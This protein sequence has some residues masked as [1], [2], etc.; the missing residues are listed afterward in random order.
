MQITERFIKLDTPRTSLIF[1]RYDELLETVYYGQRVPDAEDFDILSSHKHKYAHS[2]ID[3]IVAANMTFSCYGMGNDR[4]FSLSVKNHDG[5]YANNFL[6]VRAERVEKP[7]I[8]GLPS[9]DG[10]AETLVLVYEDRVYG[11]ELRQYYSVFD[12]T[13]AVAVSARLINRSEHAVVLRSLASCQL[14][15]DGSGYEIFSYC[16]TWARERYRSRTVLHTGVFEQGTCRGSS[17]HAVNPFLLLRR[18]ARMGGYL[19]FN[20]VYSGNHREC[21]ESTAMHTTRILIGMG[22]SCL[23]IPLG[24]G[25]RFHTPEAVMLFGKHRRDVAQQMH[26]FVNG[27]IVPRRYRG[28]RPVAVN[29]WEACGFDFD[30]E[31]VLAF[32][33]RAASVGAELLVVDDGWFGRRS[34][35]T[36]SLGDW[37]DNEQKTGGLRSLAAEVRARGLKFGIWI[38]PEMVSPDSD[39][40]RAHP[41]YVLRNPARSPILMRDQLV[42]DLVRPEVSDYLFGCIERLMDLCSPE[43][44]KWDFNR[45]ITDAYHAPTLA[46]DA[47]SLQYCKAL[48]ALLDRVLT[49]WPHL[50][51]ESCAAGGGRY[52]LGMLRYTP[53]VWTSDMTDPVERAHIQEGTLIAYPQSTMSAHVASEVCVKTGRRTRLCDR[54]A[55]ALEGVFGLEYDITQCRQEEL[56]ELRA[57]I[58]FYKNYRDVLLYG[59]YYPVES[60][61]EGETAVRVVVSADKSRAV[62][63]IFKLKQVF[64]REQNRYRLEGLN[65]EATYRVRIYGQ[66]REFRASGRLLNSYG[67]ELDAYFLKDRSGVY[68]NEIN[69][70][71]LAIERC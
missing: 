28:E 55:L 51:I 58:A 39:L 14:D 23:E 31:K 18:P 63:E 66:E 44:I 52:D 15:V 49:R 25:E 21:V 50:L 71:V 7:D 24:G 27:H 48:Y 60:A 36:S 29:I 53:Q 17:S 59:D 56:D 32:A 64:N 19:A 10:A 9:S 45:V 43:Y 2:C 69:T 37:T 20:L 5:G 35:A 41:E 11:L 67:L 26:R 70:L 3:D 57:Q 4:K 1:R 22:D 62:A 61:E 65:D 40:Y 8:D 33:D 54:F 46:G 13:D 68:S 34:D 30:R 47:Y 12:D 38:E 6:F 42:L 16:G